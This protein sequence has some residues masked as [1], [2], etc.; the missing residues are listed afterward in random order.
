MSHIARNLIYR[1]HKNLICARRSFYTGPESTPDYSGQMNQDNT[2]TAKKYRDIY[3]RVKDL[4]NGKEF[5]DSKETLVD[6][7]DQM[8]YDLDHSILTKTPEKYHVEIKDKLTF[9]DRLIGNTIRTED[10]SVEESFS[11]GKMDQDFIRP[12]VQDLLMSITERQPEKVH[13]FHPGHIKSMPRIRLLTDAQLKEE[14]ERKDKE[15]KEILKMPPVMTE[16]GEIDDVLAHDSCLDGYETAKLV[17]TDI[18]EDLPNQERFI[19]VRETDGKLRKANWDER[20][21][22][23]QIYYPKTQR[24]IFKPYWTEDLSIPFSNQFHLSMLEQI[25]GQYEADS[26][27]YIRLT[28]AVYDNIDKDRLYDLLRSTRFYGCMVFYF[29]KHSSIDGLLRHIMNEQLLEHAAGLVK[30]FAL[31]KQE[32][33]TAQ[34]LN[35]KDLMKGEDSLSMIKVYIEND[36]SNIQA[37]Q[38]CMETFELNKQED[39]G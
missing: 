9:D 32:S 1:C 17:F 4:H 33:K 18:S 21:R 3:Q 24:T 25:Y 5:T 15:A 22:M 6:C 31:I 10:K 38:L 7:G 37:L 28:Q 11:V 13:A 36:A 14:F 29:A 12:E 23:L 19:V 35:E 20:D 26:P 34:I 2:L 30:L 8:V 39:T 27:D 16:R